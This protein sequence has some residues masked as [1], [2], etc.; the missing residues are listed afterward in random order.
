MPNR[1]GRQ[2]ESGSAE[3]SLR[4]MMAAAYRYSEVSRIREKIVEELRSGKMHTVMIASPHD[5][6][7]TTAVAALVGYSTAYFA[8]MKVLLADLNLRRPELHLPFGFSE[9][10]GFGEVIKGELSWKEAVKDTNLSTLK[11][12]TAGQADVDLSRYVRRSK[13]VQLFREMSEEYDMIMV[14]SSPLLVH[15]RNNVDPVLLSVVC[16][17]VVM[18]VQNN[19]TRKTDF[20]AAV[21]SIDKAGGKVTGIIQ[22]QQFQ[23][24][25][26]KLLWGL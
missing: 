23:K 11:V 17:M 20:R 6:T 1:A 4:A 13:L 21:E 7:G 2:A 10:K 5:G 25:I 19:K 22:N 18:V 9:A 16:D 8:G 14:D 26:S 3:K 24:S 12:L 15:N